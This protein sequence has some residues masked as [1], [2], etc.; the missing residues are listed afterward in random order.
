MSIRARHMKPTE[1]SAPDYFGYEVY[2][3]FQ[4]NSNMG[5]LRRLS[6]EIII[7]K[8]LRDNNAAS[9]IRVEGHRVLF[10]DETDAMLCY[11]A[12]R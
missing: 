5:A 4:A 12:F 2:F 6:K 9:F 11:L 8:W 3:G 1:I 10:R 7:R